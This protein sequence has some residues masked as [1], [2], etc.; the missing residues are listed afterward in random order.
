MRIRHAHGGGVEV[1]MS[2]EELAELGRRLKALGTCLSNLDAE[3]DRMSRLCRAAAD[4]V[5][6][7][8]AVLQ[9]EP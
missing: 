4:H 7:L 8:T 2:E 9:G 3:L 5:I 6:A 1:H